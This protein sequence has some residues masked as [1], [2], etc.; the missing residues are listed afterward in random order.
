MGLASSQRQSIAVRASGGAFGCPVPVRAPDL[1]DADL[2]FSS[3]LFRSSVRQP[4]SH[5]DP[6]VTKFVVR[7]RYNLELFRGPKPI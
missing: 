6:L 7:P 2:P 4:R 1:R 5:S 3:H